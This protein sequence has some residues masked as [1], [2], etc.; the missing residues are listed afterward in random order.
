MNWFNIISEA[1]YRYFIQF[2]KN[3]KKFFFYELVEYTS[4]PSDILQVK[5]TPILASAFPF[6]TEE[7]VETFKADFISPRKVSIIR[8]G[9]TH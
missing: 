9:D 5:W 3:S 8:L 2:V 6:E 1:K 4:E 7:H